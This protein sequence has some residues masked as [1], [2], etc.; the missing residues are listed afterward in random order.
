MNINIGDKERVC[1][2]ARLF[3]RAVGFGAMAL[4]C[5]WLAGCTGEYYRKSADNDV[6]KILAQKRK[7]ALN[8]DAPFTIQQPYGDPLA[9]L[10]K[11]RQF[12]IP[13]W[14]GDPAWSATR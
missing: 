12:V 1:P 2:R 5:A 6:Y 8:E 13:P 10:P 14:E 4:A 3:P 9:G 11:R 7:R